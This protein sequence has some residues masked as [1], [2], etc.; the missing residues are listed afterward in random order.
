M[1]KGWNV[2]V[3]R[4]IPEAALEL[5][6]AETCFDMN[7]DDRVLTREELL[8]NVQSRDGVLCLLTDTIDEEILTAARDAVIFANYA[9]GFNN[10]D[11]RA[12]T[13]KGILVTN[14]PGV[15]TD[16]TADMAWALLF[17]AA[18]RIVE[19]DKYN[20]AGNFKGWGPV[21]FLGLDI[22]GKTL[23][24]VGAGRI[25]TAFAKRAKGFDMK[26]LYHDVAPNRPF[27]DTCGGTFVDLDTLL[28]ESDFISLHV[29][30]IPETTHLIGAREFK[31]MK[32]TALLINTA[33][34]PVV[35][36]LALVEALRSG[37]I[38][39]AGLD[40]YEW[41]PKLSPGLQE[42]GNVVLAP[43]TASATLETRTNMG[44]I[45]V[46]NLLAGL[47][48]EMPPNCVNPEASPKK[49]NS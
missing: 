48:G 46:R 4:R 23:G 32:K 38:W 47:K 31:M 36:E 37:E 10:V 22:T 44:I 16:A 21:H 3:T 39:G 18:R 17:S 19:S 35:D 12:A 30:L 1:T 45:A 41:E 49:N 27:E 13:A 25:G 7:P 20:R 34:G 9:V 26:I 11:V 28:A 33:R 29:P 15:L 14:T 8:T 43:H 42:L 5:L 6:R 24:V 40:V 2:Y